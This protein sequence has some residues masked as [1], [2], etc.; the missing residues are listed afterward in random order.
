MFGEG[1]PFDLR[2]HIVR[3][4]VKVIPTFWV[5]A[6]LLGWDPDRMD[7]VAIWMACMF[8]SILIHELGH[9]LTAEA[10]G[11]E[12][13][14]TLYHFGG[15]ARFDPGYDF[16]PHKSFLITLAGP[17]AGFALAGLTFAVWWGIARTEWGRH[18]YADSAIWNLLWINIVWGVFNLLPLLPLDGGKLLEATLGIFG[19]RSAIEWTL[20]VSVLTGVLAALAAYQ[21][22]M[23][24][25]ALF[26]GLMT[27]ENIQQIQAR[28]W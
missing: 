14:I 19:V 2:M 20:K 1:T 23:M 18:E 26:L 4:P 10:F 8:F 3:I 27:V 9:A 16:P 5:V 11:Y 21:F 13:D 7:L 15:F 6:A 24:G 12:A 22:H 25:V 28:R 17:F